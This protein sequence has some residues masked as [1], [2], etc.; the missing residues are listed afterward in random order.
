MIQFSS[1]S[2]AR[3]HSLLVATFL[4]TASSAQGTSSA[5]RQHFLAAQQDQQQGDLDAAAR[6]YQTVLRLQ[7]GIA[8][9]YVNLGLVYY[10]QA[11]F[12]QS[13]SALSAANRIKPGM[14]GVSLWLG[15]DE[16]KLHQPARGATL[17]RDAVRQD[18]ADKSAQSWLGTALWN[19]G[20]MDAA[21]IQLTSASA[22][23]PDDP[24][25]IFARG[26]AYG[27]AASQQTEQLLQDTSGTALSDLIY[28]T[29]YAGEHEWTKAEAHLRRAIERDPHLID[30]R[31]E[32]A[33]VFLQQAN[34]HDA[35]SQLDQAL[36]LDPN[37][38]SALALSGEVLILLQKQQAGIS[39]IEEA[40]AH[41]QSEALDTLG[42][43]AERQISTSEASP[44]LA[45]LCSQATEN[46]ELGQP[47]DRLSAVAFAALDALSGNNDAARRAYLQINLTA[48]RVNGPTSSSAEATQAFRQHRYEDAERA[49]LR[50][51]TSH[52]NNLVMRYR[53]IQVRRQIS[54]AQINR[55]FAVAPDSYHIHQLLGQLYAS[56]TMA[57]ESSDGLKED[58]KAIAEYR[59][60]VAEKPDLAGPHFWLGHLYWKHGDAEHAYTEL[61]RE[62]ELDPQNA[63]AD[64]ELGAILVAQ[65]RN[66]QAIPHLESA[67][68]IMPELWPAYLDL[69]NAYAAEE[70]YPRAEQLLKRSVA[71]DRD[72]SAHYQLGLVL[73]AEGKTAQA[74]EAFAQVHA[75][76]K[77]QM[78][79]PSAGED[80]NANT[81]EAA[82]P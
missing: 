71:H 49:L 45:A 5:V 33:Q 68:R 76:K 48:Q 7:P 28:G 31:L 2:F 79:A 11:K 26:E 82:Q 3:L 22:F 53:L 70:N 54:N 12:D 17:L 40:V 14:R 32:L 34:L 67:I 46:L 47:S 52:P 66:S 27:K 55:L 81:N 41:N 75:I 60:V 18:P 25:L 35:Q 4:A 63:E 50:W 56:L 51:I 9:A 37:S 73:R 10:A 38:A 8:E 61:T 23:F 15:V 72:G 1:R 44:E 24:D 43:P 77:E 65:G 64:A 29:T 80:E 59:A 19:A 39:R 74:A 58:D 20:Q 30:A 13:A 36:V 69:G 16:V 62:L 21:L 42:L 6:E 57:N 78:A